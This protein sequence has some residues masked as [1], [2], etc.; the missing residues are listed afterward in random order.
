MNGIHRRALCCGIVA[1]AVMGTQALAERPVKRRMV[2]LVCAETQDRFDDIYWEDGAYLPDAMQQI[3]Y[4]LRDFHHDEVGTIDP[5]LIDLLWQLAG[6]ARTMQPFT[7]LSGYRTTKT[8]RM[9]RHEGY[10]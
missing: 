9:L 6:H 2:H 4:V 8:N 7:V 10:F 1:T 3:N 5:E